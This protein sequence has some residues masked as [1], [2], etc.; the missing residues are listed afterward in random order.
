MERQVRYCTTEDGVRIAYTVAG[1]GPALVVKPFAFESFS[2]D[3]F[4]PEYQAFIKRLGRGRM[5]IQFDHRGTGL[6]QRQ[7]LRVDTE[8]LASDLEAVIRAVGVPVS[9][10]CATLARS[11]L[12]LAATRSELL[13]RFIIYGT[14]SHDP[15]AGA[16]PDMLRGFVEVSRGN[17]EMAVQI[18]ADMTG[19]REFPEEAVRIATWFRESSSAEHVKD[20]FGPAGEDIRPLLS[21]ISIPTLIL[22]R[23]QDPTVAFEYARGLAAAI[24]NARLVPLPGV[25]HAFF[26]G[27][28]EPVLE[29][30]NTFL[31][32]DP[33]TRRQ[34]T[35]EEVSE[36]ATFRAV[37]FTDVVE[38][39]SMMRR[40]G[41]ERGRQALR[42]HERVTR[43]ILKA[44][45]GREVKTTGDGFMASFASVTRAVECAIALQR[46]L[47]TEEGEPLSVRVGLNVGE[48]IEEEGDLFGATVILASRIAAKAEGGE[49][50]VANAVRELCAGKKFLFADRGEFVAKG[51]ED[52][53]HL[54][55]VNWRS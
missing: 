41:D 6:S 30:V 40:L 10:W 21:D 36:P 22:H 45:S 23:V 9:L 38:H 27:E 4:V 47:A 44:H 15:W 53:V 49:I 50:L 31:D 33:E 29:A 43:D 3:S 34:E 51:F 19:R 17:W 55:E 28:T 46:A 42:N 5:L 52:P 13:K 26:L 24:P 8:A 12:F 32:E 54:Y 7:G 48:P 18:F 35:G 16:H 14:A 39:T 1:H 25:G 20:L 2:L 37:L 11:G